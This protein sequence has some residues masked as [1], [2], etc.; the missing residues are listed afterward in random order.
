ML[1]LA[2]GVL[3][4]GRTW[5]PPKGTNAL[6]PEARQ[7]RALVVDAAGVTLTEDDWDEQLLRLLESRM[8]FP[9]EVVPPWATLID[10]GRNSNPAGA[11]MTMLP[12][13]IWAATSSEK[14]MSPSEVQVVLAPVESRIALPPLAGV[15]VTVAASAAD[16]PP[17]ARVAA[18]ADA[19]STR[20]V[21]RMRLRSPGVL[22]APRAPE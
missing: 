9:L 18:S 3:A 7:T 16:A 21:A 17:T 4:V 2:S 19:V 15:T 13:P 10:A 8:R 14:V 6:S 20:A 5:M 22:R 12:R 11:L 1:P